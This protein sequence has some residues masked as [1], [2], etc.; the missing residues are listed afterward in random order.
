MTSKTRIHFARGLVL[1]ALLLVSAR[2]VHAQPIQIE[3][4]S[5][6]VTAVKIEIPATRFSRRGEL[7]ES[8]DIDLKRMAGWAMNYLARTPRPDRNFEPVFQCHPRQCPPVPAGADPVVACDTDARMDW[9]WY[10][11]R[12]V[13]GSDG[14]RDIEQAFHKRIRSYIAPDG[15]VWATPGAFNESDINANYTENDR[16]IHI[17]GS[18]KVLQSLAEHHARHRDEESKVLAQKV[19]RALKSLASWDQ[20]DGQS[21]CWFRCGMGG[22]KPDGAVV[23]NGWNR[24]P[25]PII[26]PLL[27]Y[28]LATGDAEALSFARAY[29]EGMITSAQP[30]GL[31]FG[32]DGSFPGGHSHATMHAVWGIA[33]LG[34]LTKEAR[35]LSFAKGAF[36]YLLKRGTGTGW[37]PAGPDNCNETCCVSDMIS[38]AALLG[39]A[40]NTAYY[41]Y[42][43]RY[44]R[45]YIASL[46]FIVTPDFE[47][48]YQN[49]HQEKGEAAI[50]RGLDELRKFQGGIIGG[51]GLNDFENSLLG[52]VS[53]FE[54]FGCCAPEGMRAIYTIW[55]NSIEHRAVSPTGPAGVYVN[56]SF[57][58]TSAWADVI[59]SLP[60]EGR[61]T[62]KVK[63]RDTFF[64]RPPHWAPH[65][66]I[67]TFIN[68]ERAQLTWRDGYISV[69]AKPGHEISLTYPL[70]SFRQHVKNLW[71]SKPNLETT[72]HWLGNTVISAEPA[73]TQTPLFSPKP[74]Q[75][76]PPPPLK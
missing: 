21:R 67:Q 48:Y 61:L 6:Q 10:Y 65:S 35:Y 38:I 58:R 34:A 1:A 7:P 52:N 51:S 54:M 27:T 31:R 64:I 30:D 63:V 57:S 47:R 53:G 22:L 4:L 16:I 37:F 24:Q 72:F 76:P 46:Q 9:E 70:I 12:E 23:P 20:H 49:L 29:A 59:S 60:A 62:V 74:R 5:G 41:D 71:Q 26:E 66:D 42:A 73:P 69:E 45:N 33:H 19:M 18:T 3:G 2:S 40:G 36:D 25:A 14:A 13:S 17:W 8:E 68:D 32:A 39:H 50:A 75:L 11:M 28:Y 55:S 56:L 15:K 43:E 44:F